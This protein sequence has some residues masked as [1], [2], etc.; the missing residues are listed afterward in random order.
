MSSGKAKKKCDDAKDR[1]RR[2][3]VRPFEDDYVA[4]AA[5]KKPKK[6]DSDATTVW[7][8]DV[9]NCVT[10]SDQKSAKEPRDAGEDDGRKDAGNL[11]SPAPKLYE[12]TEVENKVVTQMRE[13][14][15][16]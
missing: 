16:L 12:V 3:F 1:K 8:S 6:E 9:T 10:D 15:Q 14:A 7:A 5:S 11:S 13:V 4:T 2:L